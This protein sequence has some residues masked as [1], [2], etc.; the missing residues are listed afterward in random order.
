MINPNDNCRLF[1][2]SANFCSVPW[3]HFGVYMNGDITTCSKGSK[4]GNIHTI[5]DIG[6]FFQ[7]NQ[8]L[9]TIR[10]NLFNDITD[11]NCAKCKS[12][13][14]NDYSFLRGMYNSNFIKSD[15]AYSEDHSFSLNGIDLHWGSTCQLKCITC[16]ANQSS[17]IAKEENKPIL[18]VTDEAADKIIKLVANNQ[19]TITELYLS[20]GEPTLIAHNYRLLMALDPST[21]NPNCQIRVNSNLMF[22][23]NNRI[24]K[25]LL[26]FPNVLVTV[27]ADNIGE[28]F[29]YVRRGASWEQFVANL[30]MLKQTHV[31]LRLNSVFFV[32]NAFDISDTHEYFMD[33][34]AISDITINQLGMGH[35]NIL[36]RNLDNNLKDLCKTKILSHCKKH[37]SDKNL[38]GQLHNCLNE[39]GA[40]KETSYVPFFE[41]V[42]MKEGTNWKR[43]FKELI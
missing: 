5:H 2:N 15:V 14:C 38:Q 24:I 23:S 31:K 43:I 27:S 40:E 3:N 6:E 36:C 17:S 19:T 10:K 32:G 7:D 13:E 41:S 28:R 1:F 35:S 37:A 34:F 18:S 9:K 30:L 8:R 11:P 25:E 33:E 39:L 4:L 42:D 20:G 12:M 21:L 16:W 29:E 26:K 22:K